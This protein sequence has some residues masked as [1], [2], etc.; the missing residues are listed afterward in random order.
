M[1]AIV[2]DIEDSAG[3]KL[4]TGPLVSATNLKTVQRLS[5]AGTLTF[6]VPC[7]DLKTQ[8]IT[9]KRVARPYTRRNGAVVALPAGIVDSIA[10]RG[11]GGR[12]PGVDRQR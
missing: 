4:G 11:R 9:A 3:A 7:A 5:K 8:S 1:P 12:P 2:V 6:D 10:V